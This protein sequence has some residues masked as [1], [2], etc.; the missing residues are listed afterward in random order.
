MAT[1]RKSP[2][3]KTPPTVSGVAREHG[4]SRE[5]IRKIRD[6]GVDLADPAA[7]AAAV[8]Q[9][10]GR[11]ESAPGADTGE[12]YSEARRRREIANANRAEIIARKEAGLY[13][14]VEEVVRQA[15]AFGMLTRVRFMN[16]ANTLPDR[17]AGATAVE[18]HSV[19]KKEIR[20]LL[21][22]MATEKLGARHIEQ[23]IK[24]ADD[25]RNATN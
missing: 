21:E 10:K 15:Q 5:A 6:R 8:S 9:M 4:A 25:Y 22:V 24:T 1:R 18:I 14:P 3:K 16:L 17:L 20:H 23:L 7:V 2:T 12:S 19:L 11:A 13:L